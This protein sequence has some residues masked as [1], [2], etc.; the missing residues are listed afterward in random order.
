MANDESNGGQSQEQLPDLYKLLGIKPLESDPAKIQRA[1]LEMKRKA[2]AAQKSDAKLAQRAARIVALGKK[3][4]LEADRKSN[5]DRAWTKTFG[6]TTAPK[7]A[8]EKAAAE[9][10]QPELE[11]DLEELESYLPAEDPRSAFD[12]GGFLRYSAS[13]PDS[14][15][16][17]DYDKLQSFL[18]GT[19]T[20]TMAAPESI[21]ATA[22]MPEYDPQYNERTATEVNRPF[23]APNPSPPR[24]PPGGY[25]KQIQRKRNRAML[26]SVGG[27]VGSFA[28]VAGAYFFWANSTKSSTKQPEQLAQAAK[29]EKAK[30]S[31]K[32]PDSPTAPAIPQ[33]SGL[34][35]VTGLDGS[36]APS[37]MGLDVVNMGAEKP[38][39][40]TAAMPTPAPNESAAA[41][42]TPAPT[43]EPTTPPTT[44]TPSDPAPPTPDPTPAPAPD[45]VLTDA[46]KAKWSKG[47]KELLKTLGNQD[48][49]N[50]KKQLTDLE[51]LA[52][53]QLQKDQYKRI[54]TLARLTEEYYGFLTDA[55]RGLGATETFKIGGSS[56]AAFIDGNETAVS[57]RIRGKNQ[58]FKLTELQ[59]G[60]AHG[61]VDLKMDVAH[62]SSLARKA[63]FVLVHPKTN[64]LALKRAREQMAEAA[65]AGAVEADMTA[66]FDEDYSLKK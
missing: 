34:P 47:M 3:N 18:G 8:V 5:Y 41:P 61:L 55:I 52:V 11:W 28:L 26:L 43:T 59:I 35:K 63:A 53:T 58:T 30:P 57:L 66:I 2:E 60:V 62:P 12:L 25:A 9:P 19:A 4:L 7:A 22:L 27:V 24:I 20:A 29:P 1:L 45:P 23:V 44:P 6:S 10:Q 39:E 14:N 65:G 46:D 31:V 50:A 40:N 17:A 13:L 51:P 48:F 33:G 37:T 54:S 32:E 42:T 38:A 49:V 15:P 16:S 36:P 56:E 21:S 64:D